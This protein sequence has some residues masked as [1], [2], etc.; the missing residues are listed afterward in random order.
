M[1]ISVITKKETWQTRELQKESRKMGIELELRDLENLNQ[2]IDELGDVVFWRANSMNL[3]DGGA[4][5]I[6]LI[7]K[8]GRI[9]VSQGISEFPFIRNKLFQQKFIEGFSGINTIETFTFANKE[10]LASSLE[11]GILNF[12]FVQKPAVGRRGEGV[13]LIDSCESMEKQRG[14][15]SKVVYQNF[16]KNKGDFR[17]LVLGGKPLGAIKRVARKGSFLNNFSKGGTCTNIDDKEVRE[18]LFGIAIKVASYFKLAFCGVDIIFDENKKKYFFLEVNTLPQWEGF[19]GATN[20]NVSFELLNFFKVMHER[21]RRG[22]R[23]LVSEY[24]E[25]NLDKLSFEKSFHYISRLFLW[26]NRKELSVK[27]ECFKQGFIGETEDD[28][29]GNFRKTFSEV[30]KYQE[31]VKN[32]ISAREKYI[33]KYPLL[34]VY[35]RILFQALISKTVYKKDVADIV[36]KVLDR[37]HALKMRDELMGDEEALK[38]LSTHAINFLYFSQEIFGK[39]FEV[40]V[41]KLHRISISD[42]GKSDESLLLKIY[43][44]THCI[45]GESRF[46]SQAVNDEKGIYTE[47]I[48]A[49]EEII[50]ENYF[51]VSLDNKMEFLV[52]SRMCG[53]K[54]SV[55]KILIAEAESSMSEIGN[56]IVDILN[57]KG[58]DKRKKDFWNSEHRNV[59][60]LMATSKL[61]KW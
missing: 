29:L 43:F 42:F 34:G 50:K 59:L 9:I 32:D 3:F 17:V 44:L 54:S 24:Y 14:E 16:I 53:F 26:E 51:R 38:S 13:K 31:R 55:E 5:T 36:S 37:E 41:K 22:S 27:L 10:D 60:Y 2:G 61:K 18:I 30:E 56:Y 57:A 8:S 28:I 33:K 19:Q 58:G 23:E 20:I 47:M 45:I 12:P 49:L 40:D 1:K 7:K 21:G 35:N 39:F 25:D 6:S 46:Y 48:K 11:E 15:Y 4:A 52:C